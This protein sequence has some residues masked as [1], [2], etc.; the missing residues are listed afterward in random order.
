MP[1]PISTHPIS[2]LSSNCWPL[3]NRGERLNLLQMAGWLKYYPLPS[4]DSLSNTQY[5][6]GYLRIKHL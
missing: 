4:T 5:P 2:L 3:L 6:C 1:S